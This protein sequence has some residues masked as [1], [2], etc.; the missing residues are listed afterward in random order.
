MVS[1]QSLLQVNPEFCEV[2]V[3]HR[4]VIESSQLCRTM[5][6][7]EPLPSDFPPFT[8]YPRKMWD[9]KISPLP[10]II[11]TEFHSHLSLPLCHV[12]RE[13]KKGGSLETGVYIDFQ[14]FR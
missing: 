14:N 11:A 2:A 5:E 4:E 12:P 7:L 9:R 10:A 1:P 13:V 6:K 8:L 3:G